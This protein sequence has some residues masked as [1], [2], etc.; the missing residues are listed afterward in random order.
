MRKASRLFFSLLWTV[1]TVTV[2]AVCLAVGRLMLAPIN[3]DFAKDN[4]ISQS[5]SLLPGWNI[6]YQTAKIG[7]DWSS[8]RPWLM[9]ENITLIDRRDRLTAT[10]PKAE[11]G[12]GFDGI[13]SGVGVSTVS[14]DHARVHV[15]DLGGF[16][17]STDDSLFDDLFGAG[18]IPKPEV[19]VPLTEAFSR[20]SNRLLATF[21]T[22]ESIDFDVLNVSLYRGENLPDAQFSV[23]S[24]QLQHDGQDIDLSAQV[25]I[26]VDGTP[27]STR[28]IGKA[29]PSRET[30][31]LVLNASDFY[32][33]SFASSPGF[34]KL[35]TYAKLPIGLSVS[36]ELNS[37]V[38]LQSAGIE[39]V[40]GE[41]ELFDPKVF[42]YPAAIDFGLIGATFDNLERTL[43]LDRVD[44]SLG[45]RTVSGNGLLYWHENQKNPGMQ[46]DLLTQAVTVEEIL[47]YWPTRFHPD[48]RERG[49]RAW[50]SQNMIGGDTSNVT[51]RVAVAPDGKGLLED[52]SP[53]QLNFDFENLDTKFVRTMPPILDATGNAKLTEA[54]FSI[55]LE[56]GTLQEMPIAGTTA[57]L[58][59]IDIPFGAEGEFNIFTRGS[60]QTVMRLIDYPPIRV[61]EKAKLDINRLGGNAVLKA[62]VKLPLLR[63]LPA[64]AVQYDVSA[65]VSDASVADILDGNGLTQA[66]ISLKVNNEGITA[67]GAGQLNGVPVNLRWQEDFGAKARGEDSSLIVISGTLDGKALLSLNVD[68]EDY[69]LTPAPMEIAL[70]GQDLKLTHGSFTTDVSDAVLAVPQLAWRKP[71]GQPATITGK[72][73]FKD[74]LTRVSPL[75]AQGEDINV[76]A[77]FDF[78][79]NGLNA[80]IDA[81]EL[82][83]SKFS[84][85][86][87]QEDGVLDVDVVADAFDLGAYLNNEGSELQ[88]ATVSASGSG[89]TAADVPLNLTLNTQTT[90]LRN[91]EQWGKTHIDLTFAASEPTSLSLSAEIDGSQ[92]PLRLMLN[93]EPDPSTGMRS[94]TATGDDGGA[95][96]RGLG[97]FSHVEGGALELEGQSKG[98]GRNWTIN[99]LLKVRD[100]IVVSKEKLAPEV[101]EGTV[102]GIDDYI[103]GGSLQLDVLDVPFS[104]D[105]SILG[106]NGL[107]ANGPTAGITM[108]G[109][110]ATAEGLL[111]VNG[112]VVPAYGINSLL[113]NIPLVGGL[114][115][116][117]DGKGLFGVAYRVKGSTEAPDVNV[118]ALSGLAPGFLRLLFE[119]RKGRVA[120][121]EAPTKPEQEDA[122]VDELGSEGGFN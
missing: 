98:W 69:L 84:A 17:D 39:A 96:L 122:T 12:I 80:A 23:S 89:Q 95:V 103:E 120:D 81:K 111:N 119:G 66:D 71:R 97:F 91:G 5:V 56:G 92:E 37:S 43:S 50:V 16:S 79:S 86:L 9:M 101:T 18:G 31:S 41:G 19:F 115:T 30:M 29:T 25:G 33:A 40:L 61:A 13:L 64:D 100:G 22:F 90:L 121:V 34:P 28:L 110:I 20:F 62:T 36:L 45:G 11:V 60:V 42:P 35:L 70:Q 48:G 47:K 109:E 74:N 116:G 82:G 21:P 10:I 93:S 107:K 52:E 27:V 49:A 77:N 8:V 104:Y 112:V 54:D 24:L 4:I 63:S 44:L 118:N 113:G 53:Y 94:I 55:Q 38:G 32:P 65:Q 73:E 75:V 46:L 68:V 26:A 87:K 3:L 105:G 102:S 76:T 7:W 58:T 15:I 117:G 67:A 78:L 59:G 6:D 106:L 1:L 72:V 88:A 14:L 83:R 2:L 57:L 99:G 85:T 51:F 108:E 114:F